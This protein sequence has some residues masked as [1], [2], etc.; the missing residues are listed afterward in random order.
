LERSLQ[1]CGQSSIARYGRLPSPTLHD[2][3]LA[4]ISGKYCIGIPKPKDEGIGNTGNLETDVY[5]YIKN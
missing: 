5:R 2:Y 4:S 3:N 1:R